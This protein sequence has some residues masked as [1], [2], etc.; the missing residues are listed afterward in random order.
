MKNDCLL[1]FK[2]PYQFKNFIFELGIYNGWR[3]D[4]GLMNNRGK[5]IESRGYTKILRKL[6]EENKLFRK[7][8]SIAEIVSFLD[9]F[10]HLER[11]LNLLISKE[12]QN[13]IKE[14]EIL[15]EYKIEMSKMSRVDCIIKYKHRICLFELRTVD[16]FNKLKTAY[17]KKRIELMIYKDMMLNYMDKIDKIV[18]LPLIG[19]YEYKDK[20]LNQ[21]FYENNLK[22]AEFACEYIQ[23]YILQK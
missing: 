14:I 3:I 9:T 19:L 15:F 7:Q 17:D 4:C 18:V 2:N 21:E 8:V 5:N 20:K 13:I 1:H 11:V 16:S 23:R 10:V 22:N 12:E 6:F